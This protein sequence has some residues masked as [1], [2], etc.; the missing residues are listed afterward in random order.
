MSVRN[1]TRSNNA[2]FVVLEGIDGS[3]TTTQ[4]TALTK[5]LLERGHEVLFTNE[6]SNGPAGYLIRLAL[7][8]R[9]VGPPVPQPNFNESEAIST[10][11]D[12]E[13]FALLFAADRADHISSQIRPALAAG[14]HVICDRY[15]LS[16]LAYQGLDMPPSW[17]LQIN[18]RAPKPDVTILLDVPV[19]KSQERM[20][21]TRWSKDIF[22]DPKQLEKVRSQYMAMKKLYEKNY[23]SVQIVDSSLPPFRVQN[24]IWEKVERLFD[25]PTRARKRPV[26]RT[27]K[28]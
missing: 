28:K 3:G 25:T 4:G 8:K 13:T 9:L 10:A 27:R 1:L 22:E 15:L 19:S 11:L 6:P 26:A 17:I 2:K 18:K 5:E 23:G 20:N 21:R 24:L 12:S 14:K 7:A 16:S